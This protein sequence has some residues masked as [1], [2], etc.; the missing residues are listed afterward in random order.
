MVLKP[1]ALP[2]KSDSEFDLGAVCNTHL[3]QHLIVELGERA[4]GASDLALIS[5]VV[6]RRRMV[7]AGVVGGIRHA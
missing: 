5:P 4:N 7:T 6:P 2:A 3:A 1:S